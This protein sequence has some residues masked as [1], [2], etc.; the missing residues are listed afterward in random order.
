MLKK[1]KMFCFAR[2]GLKRG[3]GYTFANMVTSAGEGARFQFASDQSLLVYFDQSKKKVRAKARRLQSQITVHAHQQLRKLLRPL[4]FDPRAVD[5]N[6]P[7][8]ADSL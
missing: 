1:V 7:Y 2:F 6:F 4:Q 8:G 3:V 5:R